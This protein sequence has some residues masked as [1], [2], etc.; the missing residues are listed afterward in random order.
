MGTLNLMVYRHSAFY[1]PLIAG[2]AGGFF[3]AEGFDPA[4]SVMQPGK[5]V[6]EML[7]SGA[8]H[9]SQ[10]AVSAAWPFLEKRERPPFV[11]FAQINQRDGFAI[12]SRNP[13]PEFG[14]AKLT[15]GTFVYAHGGQPQA[16]LAYALHK[17]GVSLDRTAGKDAG[18][19]QKSM[20]AFRTGTG[21][22]YHEQ[23]PYPQQLQHEG[24]AQVVASVGE[25][26]GPVAFSSL[27]ALPRWLGSPDAIRF[28]RAYRKARAWVQE[29]SAATVAATLQGFF[30]G[31]APDAM[32]AAIRYYQNLGCWAG[33]IAIDPAHY[34]TALDVFL[35]SKL[36]TRRHPYD[37]VI[38]PL[39]H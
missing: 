39:P 29:T 23:A 10:S 18:D 11:S 16:M 14:W 34:E 24:V 1:S 6:A 37:K 27:V 13:V 36:I 3:A 20:A 5:S 8:I 9:V 28:V 19:P 22:W 15:T 25:V 12:A 2:I 33:D 7:V 31:I 26:I 38:A 35:H 4:Y 17:K 21:D 30:P 32:L